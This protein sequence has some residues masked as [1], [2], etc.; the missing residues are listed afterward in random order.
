M[1]VF[2]TSVHTRYYLKIWAYPRTAFGPPVSRSLP[3]LLIAFPNRQKR[4]LSQTATAT[5]TGLRLVRIARGC[6]LEQPRAP[7]DVRLT[8]GTHPGG[9]GGEGSQQAAT[10]KKR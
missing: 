8:Q 1:V 9:G 4:E 6:W 3:A 5:T 7:C 10:Q 2:L